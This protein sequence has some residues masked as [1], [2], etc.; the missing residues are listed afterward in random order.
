MYKTSFKYVQ[1]IDADFETQSRSYGYK[2]ASGP[3]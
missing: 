2:N 1:L 3:P